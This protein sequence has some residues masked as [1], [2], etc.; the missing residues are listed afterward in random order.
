M[1]REQEWLEY[2]KDYIEIDP[3]EG[4]IIWIKKTGRGTRIGRE[5]G[6]ID[7]NGYCRFTWNI[8]GKQIN[9]KIHRIIWTFV[10]GAIPEEN[11]IHH[12]DENPLNNK[13][14]NLELKPHN[15]HIK[16]HMK[17]IS[18]E[19]R[20]K[21]SEAQQGEKHHNHKLSKDQIIEIR[22]RYAEGNISQNKL[23]EEYG[24]KQCQI[25]RI[26]N[27]KRWKHFE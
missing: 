5:I 27:Y 10:K 6:S 2:Y 12:K 17:N 8:N 3:E 16:E 26:I 11:D 4:K 19:T 1:T 25:W 14:E 18:N 21:M 23:A 13:I 24:V 20:Q 15:K 22:R 7:K 9:I